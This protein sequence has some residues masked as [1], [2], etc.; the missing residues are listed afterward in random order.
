MLRRHSVLRTLKAGPRQDGL[1]A[2]PVLEKAKRPKVLACALEYEDLLSWAVRLR[3][4]Y[5]GEVTSQRKCSGAVPIVGTLQLSVTKL[6]QS[7]L[8]ILRSGDKEFVIIISLFL[9][10]WIKKFVIFTC[11]GPPRLD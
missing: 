1:T 6:F 2:P 9:S 4:G 10:H 5:A 7:A 8:G 11:P 3:E